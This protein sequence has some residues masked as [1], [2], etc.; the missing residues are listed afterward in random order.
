M[1][2]IYEKLGAKRFFI[3]A[4]SALTAIAL[5]LILVLSLLPTG[6]THLD[7]TKDKKYG[8]T[9]ESRELAASVTDEVTLYLIA[10][11][12]SES[13]DTKVV[14]DRYAGAGSK[15]KS[16]ILYTE[17][18]GE[19][20][21]KHV[22]YVENTEGGIIAVSGRRSLYIPAHLLVSY[23]AEAREY[24]MQ[25]YNYYYQSGET[26]LTFSDFL[27]NNGQYYGLFDGDA[28]ESRIN[29]A[30]R[31]VTSDSIKTF[32]FASGKVS[33]YFSD[34]I[35]LNF[36]EN[37][38]ELKSLSL[39]SEDIPSG[40]DGIM[41]MPVQK[42]L[43]DSAYGK[44]SAYLNGG[45][46]V[47]LMSS[48]GVSDY[49]NLSAL[50]SSFGLSSSKNYVFE[51]NAAHYFSSMETLIPNVRDEAIA[52]AL[53]DSQSVLLPI[54]NE[55]KQADTLPS[56]VTVQPLLVSSAGSYVKADLSGGYKFDEKTDVRGERLLAVKATNGSGGQ[57]VYFASSVMLIDDFD[58][59]SSDGNKTAF[60][61]VMRGFA[62]T[63]L[64]PST[65]EPKPA[66]TAYLKSSEPHLYAFIITG[67]TLIMGVL[68]TGII[69]GFKR[70]K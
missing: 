46:R 67:A 52:E 25:V 60:F 44:L 32:Y 69:L 41:L 37:M 49:K 13:T 53:A 12:K 1:K 23:S 54:C 40:T 35:I 24:A 68:A 66:V 15:I 48:Y 26:S 7:L 43:S 45:G 17:T 56:G 8:L 28:H 50:C 38:I 27:A 2:K 18:D 19:L 70:N 5:A 65:P 31:F 22:S 33:E 57:L 11:A 61:A 51:D 3:T 55:I 42:D 21:K 9:A 39:D 6:V 34:N 63:Q 14:L 30:L 59:Y 58:Y 20:I 4:F 16:K 47:L 62:D 10:S 64:L 29:T 36:A